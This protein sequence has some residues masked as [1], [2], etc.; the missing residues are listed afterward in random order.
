MLYSST[1]EANPNKFESS[2]FGDLGAVKV[3]HTETTM[4]NI[5]DTFTNAMKL[6]QDS[7]GEMKNLWSFKTSTDRREVL[8]GFKTHSF[9]STGQVLPQALHLSPFLNLQQNGL[10]AV[11]PKN[12]QCD[13][14]VIWEQN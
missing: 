1:T 12:P 11:L 13:P 8:I 7:V 6:F 3:L 10:L 5:L 14:R 9:E 4:T 2:A